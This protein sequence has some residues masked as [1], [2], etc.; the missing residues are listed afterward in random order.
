MN[1]AL[2]LICTFF[3]A[4]I[5]AIL[6]SIKKNNIRNKPSS[7]V[8]IVIALQVLV[9]ILFFANILANL[10]EEVVSII[11]WGIVLAGFIVSIKDFK[12]NSM[13]STLCILLSICLAALKLLLFA[14]TSM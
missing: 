6:S 12:N 4:S 1:I 3:I 8:V 5:I 13:A 10:Q 11:W 2:I 7:A 14:I 9:F